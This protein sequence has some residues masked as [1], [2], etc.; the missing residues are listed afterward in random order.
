M[1]KKT[2]RVKQTME[3]TNCSAN[4]KCDQFIAEESLAK[5]TFL[6]SAIGITNHEETKSCSLASQTSQGQL[7]KN[8]DNLSAY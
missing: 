5:K 8:F 2:I 3:Q 4:K 6:E 1:D 7:V